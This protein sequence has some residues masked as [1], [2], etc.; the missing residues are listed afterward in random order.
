VMSLLAL[1]FAMGDALANPE[2]VERCRQELLARMDVLKYGSLEK[3]P[4]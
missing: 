3:Q 4:V 1:V 2:Q